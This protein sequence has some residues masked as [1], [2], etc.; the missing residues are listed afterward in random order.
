MSIFKLDEVHF[1]DTMINDGSKL[2]IHR[3]IGCE[4]VNS[5]NS[6]SMSALKCNHG[7]QFVL[8]GAKD[9]SA[10]IDSDQVWLLQST[11][12]SGELII[13]ISELMMELDPSRGGC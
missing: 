6:V 10:Y 3:P 11:T 1:G 7:V 4:Y 5:F 9:A 2:R 12:K 8:S 13:M